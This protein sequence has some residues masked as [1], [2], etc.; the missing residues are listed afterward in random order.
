MKHYRIRRCHAL[1]LTTAWLLQVF[2]GEL[3]AQDPRLSQYFN[4]PM[5][6][7]PAFIGRQVSDWCAMACYR[8]QWAGDGSQPFSTTTASLEKNLSGEN[9]HNI[10]GMGLM[11]LTDASN[12]G[13]LKRNYLSLGVSYHNA[14]DA[15]GRQFLAGGLTLN[16][17]NRMLDQTKFQFQSQFGSNGY[18]PG[19]AANDGAA[20]PENNYV[21]LNAGLYYSIHSA[22]SDFYIGAGYF[23]AGKP[24]ESAYAN[25]DFAVDPRLS[26][27]AGFEIKLGATEN[28]LA[29]SNIFDQQ[30][31]SS[32]YTLGMV[33]RLAVSGSELGIRSL[34]LGIWDRFGDA[35]YPYLGIEANNWLLGLSYDAITSRV[36]TTAMQSF[37]L[38][39]A[40]RFGSKKTTQH[41]RLLSY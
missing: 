40:C 26:L 1:L 4:S 11:F 41:N 14:L 28:R 32:L 7:N 35:V 19:M 24:K 38:S 20:I 33:Y 29:I 15:E 13:V 2:V 31:E 22:R 21:D 16:Y 25:T 34:N 37:E 36:A 39:L 27:Q 17:T 9:N 6:V 30:G 8:S 18:Q 3:H 10:L 12:G 5:T 23:H